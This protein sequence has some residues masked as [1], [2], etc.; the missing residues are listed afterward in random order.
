MLIP[1]IYLVVAA[2]AT[3]VVSV[4]S[5]FGSRHSHGHWVLFFRQG[6]GGRVVISFIVF[7]GEF[8]PG[9]G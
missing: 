2:L 4:V 8:D 6:S 5:S 3:P 7:D 1:N 9:S